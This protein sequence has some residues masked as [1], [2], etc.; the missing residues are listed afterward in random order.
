MGRGTIGGW[1]VKFGYERLA[2]EAK[3]CTKCGKWKSLEDFP[4]DRGRPKGRKDNVQL[5]NTMF[6]VGKSDHDE[7]DF[8]AMCVAVAER[9]A[10][11]P[12]V[13]KRLKELRNAEF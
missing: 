3:I 1:S 10:H 12:Q 6:N 11:D 9:H 4:R 5:V 13:I 2:D 7:I 8:I